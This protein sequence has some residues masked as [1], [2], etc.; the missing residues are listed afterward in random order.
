M[1]S[2]PKIILVF[3]TLPALAA[4]AQDVPPADL[5]KSIDELL[6]S[7]LMAATEVSNN[8]KHL[9]ADEIDSMLA[10]RNRIKA[11]FF[12]PAAHPAY[13]RSADEFDLQSFAFL[14]GRNI[15]DVDSGMRRVLSR[16]SDQKAAVKQR[17]AELLLREVK[18][19]I[20]SSCPGSKFEKDTRALIEAHSEGLFLMQS[21]SQR[22]AEI[23]VEEWSAKLYDTAIQDLQKVKVEFLN[24]AEQA[25]LKTRSQNLAKLKAMHSQNSSELKKER[26]DLLK[27]L[28]NSRVRELQIDLS[29]KSQS[30]SAAP[31]SSQGVDQL[32]YL[33]GV[34][35]P[36]HIP[37]YVGGIGQ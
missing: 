12:T 31:V 6:N 23:A 7:S 18:Q 1:R 26:Q 27:E 25:D 32:K 15:S 17:S 4:A 5:L 30:C 24:S 35:V 13:S 29:L 21:E 3:I 34:A 19:R 2:L 10:L 11:D 36:I 20:E 14:K 8:S 28:E 33:P 37:A 16:I 22:L 9:S